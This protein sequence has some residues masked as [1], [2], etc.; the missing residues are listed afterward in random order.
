MRDEEL[1][2]IAEGFTRQSD[3][4]IEYWFEDG[5]YRDMYSMWLRADV[6]GMDTLSVEILDIED[7]AQVRLARDL[8]K[9]RVLRRLL[10]ANARLE[11]IKGAFE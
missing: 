7:S 6:A 9:E 5:Y 11:E 3:G 8:L 1:Q 4:Y 10:S 2:E